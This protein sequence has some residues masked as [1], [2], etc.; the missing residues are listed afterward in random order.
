MTVLGGKIVHA[1]D[2]FSTHNPS[3]PP[4]SPDWSPIKHYG[5]YA[6]N[7]T[8]V[9]NY[10]QHLNCLDRHAADCHTSHPLLDPF[11]NSFGCFCWAI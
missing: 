4:V 6:Q 8:I 7:K 9:S 10:L 1:S 3:L 2:E 11:A 5:T